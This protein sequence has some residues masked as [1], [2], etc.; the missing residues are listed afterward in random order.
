MAGAIIPLVTAI[1][2]EIINLI[3]GLVH[4]AAPAAEATYGPST[5]PVKF[6]TVF[7]SVVTALQSAAAAGQIPK[8]LPSDP[9][10]QTVIQAVV[11]SMNLTG[12]LT[13]APAATAQPQVVT[14]KAGQSLT[15]TCG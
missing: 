13:E 5:G 2:P 3:A 11:S 14:L 8:E 15:V 7:A 10:I 6:A 12:L 4:K 1:A 9:T